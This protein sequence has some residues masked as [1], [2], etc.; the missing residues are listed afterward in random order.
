[1]VSFVSGKNRT[2]HDIGYTNLVPDRVS[3]TS[4]LYT[5]YFFTDHWRE[6]VKKGPLRHVTKVSECYGHDGSI[7]LS[8]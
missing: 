6:T 2:S 3:S 7:F 8:T 4:F 1:M 5:P